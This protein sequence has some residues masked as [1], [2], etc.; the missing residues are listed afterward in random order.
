MA[1][2]KKSEAKAGVPARRRGQQ[3]GDE[4]SGTGKATEAKKQTPALRGRR[5]DASKFFADDSSQAI[6]SGGDGSLSD[7]SP[8]VS[9][10]VPTGEKIGE[11]GGERE[12]KAR[13]KT[14]GKK[15]G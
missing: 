2:S 1:T 15:H 13:Q 14:A 5:K 6:G 12:F 9:A 8:S 11:S 7:N 4:R 10:V 3:M